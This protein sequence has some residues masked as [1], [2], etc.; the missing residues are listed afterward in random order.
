MP[1]IEGKDRNQIGLL[2]N[3]LDDYA[4]EDNLVRVIDA[5]V[6]SLNI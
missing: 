1:F 2:P 4:S 5:Y 6:D 3:T